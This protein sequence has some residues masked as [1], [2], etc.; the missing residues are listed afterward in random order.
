VFKPW[1]GWQIV[2]FQ[3]NFNNTAH[4]SIY[5][6]LYFRQAMQHLVDQP[7]WIK[8][9]L[10]GYAVP[11]YGP[12]PLQPTNNFADSFEQ[13]NPYPYDPAAAVKLLT[14]N[15]WTVNPGGVSTCSNAGTGPGQCGA[16]IAAGAKASF[17]L[18]YYSGLK[19]VEQEMEALKTAFSKAGLEL[20]LSGAPFDTVIG[21]AFAGSTAADMDNWGGGWI[22][23]PDYYPTGDEI[24]ATG[25]ISNG[26]AY[27][28][29]NNDANIATTTTSSDVGTLHA[30]EDFLTKDLPVIWIPSADAQLSMVKKTL[31]GWDP[32]DP[33]EQLYPEN[34]YFT[35]S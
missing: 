22:F 24:F 6:Q 2:Y 23:S 30:Y 21:D 26:G 34:W 11:D 1:I 27:S 25:A 17:K 16:G 14:D 29:P 31:H 33:I 28:N 19:Y 15:G 4:G 20:N 3:I 13:T 9:I 8:N 7:T 12:V 32:Q 18:E 5:K 35:S 10:K